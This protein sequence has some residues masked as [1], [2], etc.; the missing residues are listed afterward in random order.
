MQEKYDAFKQRLEIAL[1]KIPCS[2]SN[3]PEY[4]FYKPIDEAQLNLQKF[5]DG[6]ITTYEYLELIPEVEI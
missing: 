6:K 4:S 3:E 1:S 2:L 5:L